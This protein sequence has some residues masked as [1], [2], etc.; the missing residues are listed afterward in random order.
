MLLLLA[1]GSPVHAN[2]PNSGQT[3]TAQRLAVTVHADAVLPGPSLEV[4]AA[5]RRALQG[6]DWRT[7]ERLL[8][9]MSPPEGPQTAEHAFLLSWVLVAQDRAE[10]AEALVT[11]LDSRGIPATYVE[12][13]RGEVYASLGKTDQA[14]EHLGRVDPNSVIWGRAM[15][16]SARLLVETGARED[17]L[18]TL[19]RVVERRDPAPGNADALLAIAE[20]YGDE[21]DKAYPFL[22]RVWWGYPQTPQAVEAVRRLKRFTASKYRPTWREVGLRAE[23]LMEDRRAYGSVVI[24]TGRVLAQVD[25]ETLDGCRLLFARGRSQLK[26]GQRS[27]GLAT[28]KPLGDACAKEQSIYGAKALYLVGRGHFKGRRYATAAGVFG[29]IPEQYPS[30]SFADDGANFAGISFL[31]VEDVDAA[32]RTWSDAL[33]RFPSGDMSPEAAWRLALSLY[34]AERTDEAITLMDKVAELPLEQDA[35]HVAGARYWAA[36]WRLYPSVKDP[37]T[38]VDDPARRTEAIERWR[39]LAVEVPH[40][41]YATLAYARLAEVAPEVA[42]AVSARRP[43][44]QDESAWRVRLSFVEHGGLRSSIDLARLGLLAEAKSEWEYYGYDSLAPSEM[45]W[46]TQLR[47]AHGS[48]LSAHDRMRKYLRVHPPGSLGP[49]EQEV[50]RVAYP[51]RYWEVIRDVAGSYHFD[52]RLFHALVREESNFNPTITSHAGARGLSQL[53]PGTAREVAGWLR[54]SVD[55]TKLNDPRLNA[56]LGSRY[57]ESLTK[58]HKGSP[59]LALAAYNAGAGRVQQWIERFG[60]IPSDE[61]VER[62]P[63]KETRHYVKRVMGTWQLMSWSFDEGY[64]DLSAF[65]HEAWPGK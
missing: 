31:E 21:G 41:Y 4:S 14:V 63:F 26:R 60:N 25:R 46:V 18:A 59:F 11:Q 17:A 32:R 39:R 51:D 5:L 64:A 53:M 62:I 36:R 57:F 55:D 52:P 10:E 23:R 13:V 56:R 2:A 42:K 29:K 30:T 40:S 48:W 33:E 8:R 22:R 35:V 28:L 1:L 43:E 12:L 58:T 38:P 15:V 45:A 47:M 49:Q 54:M 37:G 3:A 6:R 24:E 7:S 9:K 20:L 27:A 65:N 16:L 34:D 61:Y 19:T 44:A 50:L